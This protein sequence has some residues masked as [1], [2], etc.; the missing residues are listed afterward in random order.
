MDSDSDLDSICSD[1]VLDSDSNISGLGLGFDGLGLGLGLGGLDYITAFHPLFSTT[2]Y[3]ARWT[4]HRWGKLVAP[5]NLPPPSCPNWST[6]ENLEA[7]F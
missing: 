4:F 7:T 1:S 3:I 6:L 2:N 5:A